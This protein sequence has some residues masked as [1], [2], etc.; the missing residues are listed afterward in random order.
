MF[1][2]Y[3]V[4][5]H[6]S[7]HVHAYERQAPVYRNL[8][9]SNATTYIVSGAGGNTEW[10]STLPHR[11]NATWSLF[12]NDQDFGIGRMSIDRTSLKWEFL[13]SSDG[14]LLDTVTLRK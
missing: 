12:S 7:G 11:P 9:R 5:L 8:L 3:G 4:D 10:H 6:L 1:Y 2:R 14:A 13:R